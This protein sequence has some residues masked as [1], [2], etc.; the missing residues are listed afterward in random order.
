MSK[1]W[2]FCSMGFP[3]AMAAG[4]PIVATAVD[5]NAEAV[6]DGVHGFLVPPG[7]SQAMAVALLRLLGDPTLARSIGVAGQ[8]RADEFGARKMV[9]D[10]AVLYEALLAERV[11]R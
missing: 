8:T 3:Q 6:T 5:G 11:P 1:E 7:D 10:I 2:L 4:L 9:S